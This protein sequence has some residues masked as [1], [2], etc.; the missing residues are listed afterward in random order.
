VWIA[1]LHALAALFHHAVLRDEIL[2]TMLP[3]WFPLGRKRK[4]WALCFMRFLIHRLLNRLLIIDWRQSLRRTF[5]NDN[6]DIR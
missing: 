4:A 1:G 2:T 3:R 6:A 5:F